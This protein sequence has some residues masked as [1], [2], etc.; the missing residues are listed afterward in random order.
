ME[1]RRLAYHAPPTALGLNMHHYWV[2]VALD[3]NKSGDSSVDWILEEAGKGEIFAAGHA[4]SGND[5]PVYL[6]TTRAEKVDGGYKFYGRK[7]FGSL[8]PVW[9]R[10]GIHAMDSSD[11][12]NP[13]IIHAF[14]KREDEGFEIKETWDVLGMRATKSDDTILDGVF[15]PDAYIGRIVPAGTPGADEFVLSIF[16]WA[17]TG[18]SNV[19]YGIARRVMDLT[20]E[21][22]EKKTSLGVSGSMARHPEVQ[23]N[24]AEMYTE[25]ESIGAHLDR[26]QEEWSN[27]VD[28]GSEWP[29]KI[30]AT[31]YHVVEGAWRI[32][33]TAMDVSGGFGMFKK[34]ELERLFRD[35][36]AGRFHPANSALA[37]E[38]IS[39]TIL[40]ID[41]TQP[42][43]WG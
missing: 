1:T 10:M 17:L 35:A 20:L 22:L 3:I 24:I 36:R 40:G 26:F 16:A 28:H 38:L 27:G 37:H 32:V 29:A 31:K 12:D 34:S 41:D 39:K 7:S 23:H 6:S 19:Y 33:D 4:E 15:V 18:F 42:L 2:G 8:T 30:I 25:L 13:K 5:L 9:T 21:G 11:P 43:R 14:I